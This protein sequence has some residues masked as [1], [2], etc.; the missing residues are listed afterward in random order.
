[1]DVLGRDP[2]LARIGAWLGAAAADGGASVPAGSVL[3]IEGEPGIGKTT[4]WAEAAHRAR[5]AG[6]QVSPAGRCPQTP[7]CRMSG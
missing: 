6:W 7:G 1:M 3:V 4:L 2:E 5:L